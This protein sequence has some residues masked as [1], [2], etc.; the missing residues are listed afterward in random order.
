MAAHHRRSPVHAARVWHH[1]SDCRSAE[2]SASFAKSHRSCWH[3]AIARL[4]HQ[5]PSSALEM[6]RFVLNIYTSVVPGISVVIRRVCCCVCWPR[7]RSQHS[8]C[9][10]QQPR[11]IRLRGT[12]CR[13]TRCTRASAWGQRAIADTAHA[14]AA[15]ICF[16]EGTPDG[17]KQELEVLWVLRGLNRTS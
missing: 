10:A 8:S 2:A 6:H 1:L 12:T 7:L 15:S 4:A 11:R 16:G 5:T 17:A 14:G 3:S 9:T 13:S